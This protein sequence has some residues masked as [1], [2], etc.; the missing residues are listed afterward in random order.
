V[1]ARAAVTD[2]PARSPVPP[3]PIGM[4]WAAAAALA[5]FAAGG[6]AV[7]VLGP[8]DDWWRSLVGSAPG[9]A[10]ASGAVPMFFQYLGQAPGTLGLIVVLPLALA[11]FGRWR[12]GLFVAS[13][14]LF[15]VVFL[16]QG[17]K[18][19]VDR[20]RP[21]ADAALGLYGPLVGVDHG[22]Y[23]SGHVV[24]AAFA[25]VAIAALFPPH[26]QS[27]RTIWWVVA[28]FLIV[29][30]VWQRTLVNAHWLSDAVFGA[31]AGGGGALLMWWV[32]WPWLHQDY[33]RPS[34]FRR[35]VRRAASAPL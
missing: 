15:T 23:P 3:R 31:L 16:S 11:A 8:V 30:T 5:V 10:A 13:S 20:P 4:L 25:A 29:G 6:V 33:G 18:S 12:S 7:P 22:S 28:A 27:A 34:A 1:T 26:R 24:T 32:F 21:A 17:M 2:P 19:L 9:D 35:I 14:G